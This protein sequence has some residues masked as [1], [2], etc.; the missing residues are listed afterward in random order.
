MGA[1]FRVTHARAI[2][3]DVQRALGGL[4]AGMGAESVDDGMQFAIVEFRAARR[5]PWFA[6]A[7]DAEDRLSGSVQS[8]FG[9]VLIEDLSSLGEQLAGGVPNPSRARRERR[10]MKSLTVNLYKSVHARAW[11]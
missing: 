11:F 2:V 7:G 1:K 8:F 9:V 5:G 4:G 6:F 3:E 10:D